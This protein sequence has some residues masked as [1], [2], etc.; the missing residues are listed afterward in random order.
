MF[1]LQDATLEF[2]E[3]TFRKIKKA[4]AKVK[5]AEIIYE[6]ENPIENLIEQD[7]FLD[8]E[9]VI[10]DVADNVI[11]ALNPETLLP[12]KDFIKMMA[13]FYRFTM[14]DPYEIC[15]QKVY[16]IYRDRTEL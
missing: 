8:D 13:L 6:L 14:P 11:G 12:A 15:Y 5:A 10:G 9:T 3:N 4:E 16:E 7:G 1:Y 2:P